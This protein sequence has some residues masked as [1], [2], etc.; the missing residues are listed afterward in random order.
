M[1]GIVGHFTRVESARSI[2]ISK[3]ATEVATRGFI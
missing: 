3:I 2:V 1:V